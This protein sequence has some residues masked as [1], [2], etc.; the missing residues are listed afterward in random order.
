MI[1][2]MAIKMW[3]DHTLDD[4]IKEFEDIIQYKESTIFLEKV[5]RNE[6]NSELKEVLQ[7]LDEFLFG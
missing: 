6:N 1:A 2:K 4:R 3:I 5:I 7:D